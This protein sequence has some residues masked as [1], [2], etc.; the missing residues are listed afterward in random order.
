MNI[1]DSYT[2]KVLFT[3]LKHNVKFIVVGGYAV[4]YHG[5]R[6]TT[7]DIDLLL[8]PDNKENKAKLILSFKEL[9]IDEET[10]SALNQLDF[11]KPQVFMDG[12][13]PFKIDFLTKI[14]GVEFDDAWKLKVE[15]TYDALTIPFLSYNHL[16]LS[17]ITSTRGKDKID[18]EELQK[19]KKL[20]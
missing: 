15:A 1:F 6:R 7:G 2:H 18:I 20:L 11:E 14:P 16:I 17:K 4:N 9:G 13:E 3:L 8:K 5:Y 10:L 12:E 19:I